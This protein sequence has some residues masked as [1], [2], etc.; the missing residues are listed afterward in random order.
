MECKYCHAKMPD[1]T[2]V[3]PKC[4][5]DNTKDDLKVLK[6]VTLSLVCLVMLALLVSM[7]VYGVT[8]KSVFDLLNSTEPTTGNGGS[9]AQ[10]EYK[11]VTKDGL[12]T[13]KADAIEPFMNTAVVTMGEHTMT[14]RELQLYYWMTA[15]AEKN[16]DLTKDLDKIVYDKESGQTYHEYFLKTALESWQ[17]TKVMADEAKK[18]DYQLAADVQEY[19][20]KG[21]KE[22]LEYYVT[23]YGY[24]YPNLGLKDVDD[25]IQMNFGPCMTY[26]AYHAYY[27]DYFYSTMYWSEMYVEL[28][29]TEDEINEYFAANEEK[30]ATEY[31]I[32]V[33]KD[34][35]D[36][37]DIRSIKINVIT[38][39]DE[40]GKTVEDW[41]ATLEAINKV[42]DKWVENGGTEEAFKELVA[43]NS[44]DENTKNSEGLYADQY[45][46]SLRSVDVRHI[47]IIPD[48][49]GATKNENGY[50]VYTDKAWA[51]A[52]I[53][54]EEILNT[55]LEDPT[56][57]HFG[58]LANEHS[59]D[60]K[61]KVTDG[62]IYTDVTVGEMVKEFEDWCFD[63]ARKTGDYGIV[64]TVYGYHIMYYVRADQEV[65]DWVN[66]ENRKTGDCAVLK[67]DDAYYLVYYMTSEPA[68]HRYSRFGVQ[69]EKAEA[70]LKSLI[71]ASPYTLNE[72]DMV[73]GYPAA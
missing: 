16:L 41:D 72:A 27:E 65:D 68:W 9:T 44:A 58:E 63:P 39:K 49:T 54:A 62:G 69:A 29:Y 2:A 5:K 14:N 13:M 19:L 50:T 10:T 60:K 32:P 20:D 26:D 7:V 70:I 17:K 71:D 34:F 57:T 1:N 31:A 48:T 21:M 28:E 6:I 4:G 67:A 52:K 3:C 47:L 38:K 51:S 40:D 35:G 64:K 46:G 23:M 59:E 43:K 53:D 66:D 45:R 18:H 56:E 55:W 61:G 24:Y 42:Y 22:E 36:L 11:V 12:V 37:I 33:T 15:H 8:G 73:I 25:L 30:L